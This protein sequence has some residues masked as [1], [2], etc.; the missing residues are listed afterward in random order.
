MFEGKAVTNRTEQRSHVLMRCELEVAGD[1]IQ[2]CTIQ[3]VHGLSPASASWSPVSGGRVAACGRTKIRRTVIAVKID[4]WVAHGERLGKT[5]QSVIDRAVT[6]RVVMTHNVTNHASTLAVTT[7][8]SV[9]PVVHR[10]DDASM[11][12][13]QA[14]SDIR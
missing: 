13:L 14:I 9:T 10:E 8:R 2:G 6:M 11:H 7:I 3:G 1:D 5:N 12:R 4:E